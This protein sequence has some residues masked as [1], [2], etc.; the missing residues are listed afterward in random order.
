MMVAATWR[1]LGPMNLRPYNDSESTELSPSCDLL[2]DNMFVM[3]STIQYNTIQYNT[4]QYNTI[5]YN[6]IQY[7]TIQYNKITFNS[8]PKRKFLWQIFT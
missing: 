8:P 1:P 2:L 4:I 7:N 3:P 6:T 5:Q